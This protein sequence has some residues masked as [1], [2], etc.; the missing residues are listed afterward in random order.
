MSFSCDQ[1]SQGV[2]KKFPTGI[3]LI[4][5]KTLHESAYVSQFQFC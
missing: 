5:D 4:S 1:D 3:R 2:V